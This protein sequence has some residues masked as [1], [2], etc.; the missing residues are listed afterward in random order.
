M[1]KVVPSQVVEVIDQIFPNVKAQKDNHQSRLPIGRESQNEVAAIVEL[2]N[3]IPSELIILTPE[4]YSILQLAISA[5]KNTLPIWKHRDYELLLIQGH[6]NLNPITIIRNALSK[7]PDE[8]VSESVSDLTFISNQEFRKSLRIDISSA[9]QALQNGEWKAA[10]V[11]AG[12][13][14]EALLLYELLVVQ[15][16][17]STKFSTKKDTLVSNGVLSRST[18]NDLNKWTLHQLTI[19]AADLEIIREETAIQINIARDF[20]N[21]IHPGVSVRKNIVCNRGTALSALAGLE[22]TIN[23]LKEASP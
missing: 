2:V 3:Q 9:N 10:T 17:D 5:L 18:G 15:D 19:V 11:L 14:I 12:A 13:T 8:G 21:L 22:H 7:C 16:S 6:G 1:V 20:R 23:D 4:D